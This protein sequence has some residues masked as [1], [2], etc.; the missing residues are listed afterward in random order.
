MLNEYYVIGSTNACRVR[1]GDNSKVKVEE[2]VGGFLAE[3]VESASFSLS[4]SHDMKRC[5]K[6]R[7]AETAQKALEAYKK[8]LADIAGDC[9]WEIFR[10][11]HISYDFK[12]YKVVITEV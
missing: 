11:N 5:C 12:V 6:Y 4:V 10:Q 2:I 1:S 8:L 9:S 3:D 7:D